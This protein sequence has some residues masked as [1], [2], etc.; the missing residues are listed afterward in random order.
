MTIAT[1]LGAAGM[2]SIVPQTPAQPL[3][4][5]PSVQQMANRSAAAQPQAPQSIIDFNKTNPSTTSP[6]GKDVF[7]NPVAPETTGTQTSPTD[8]STGTSA[9]TGANTGTTTDTGTSTGTSDTNQKDLSDAQAQRAQADA[10]YQAQAKQVSDT[11]TNIQNGTTALTPG[12]QAQIDGL[13]QQFQVLISAQQ[14]QNTGAQGLGNIRGYQ[15]G[16]AE[17]DPT[18]QVKTIGAIITAG[19]NKIADLNI[20]MASAVAAMTQS[21]HDNDIKAVTD[22][23]NIYK[24]AADEHQKTL[25]DTVN[26]AKDAIKS[27]QDQAKNTQDEADKLRDYNL[28]VDKFNQTGDQNAFDNALRTEQEKFNEQNQQ[29]LRAQAAGTL[30]ETARH[31][32]VEEGIAAY[33]AG[34]GAGGGSNIG[35]TQSAQIGADGRPD[36]VSQKAVLDQITQQYGPMTAKAIQNLANYS[37]NPAD[38]GKTAKNGMTH[39]T[40]V[41]LASMYDPTYNEAQYT[42][43]AGYMKNLASNQAGTVGSAINSANKSVNHLTAFVNTMAQIPNTPSTLFNRLDNATFGNINPAV[44]TA[45]SQAT[46]EGLGVAEELAKFFKGSGTVDVGSIDSW[47]SQINTNATPSDVKGM[48]QGAIDLL[49][50]QLSTLAEQYKSTM[51]KAPDNDFLNPSARA[52]LSNLKNK[53]YQV[54]IPGINYTDKTAWQNNG[55]TQDQWNSAVDALTAA[56]LPLTQENILQFAQE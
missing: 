38:Y 19:Q 48:T 32:K 37:T 23:W 26:D 51:G 21:F 24:D 3:I 43:R 49:G 20:K 13:K 12:Q 44:R 35:V 10:D 25:T 36:P 5:D 42:V 31:N 4:P 53:G 15:T 2:G 14:L 54:D 34:M 29:A 22:A 11:I 39:E 33:N 56:G 17:Y 16:A 45:K 46:T 28:N 9:S 27:A 30:A 8:T 47:K 50:G 6:T 41:T 55:G 52:S 40:A 1:P 7:G 18:F